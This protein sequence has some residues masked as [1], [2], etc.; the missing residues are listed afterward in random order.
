MKH[1]LRA[2]QLLS[3]CLLGVLALV[4]SLL[5]LQPKLHTYE[6]PILEV[7]KGQVAGSLLLRNLIAV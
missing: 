1:R 2:L 3:A 6:L 7:G 4:E 5:L